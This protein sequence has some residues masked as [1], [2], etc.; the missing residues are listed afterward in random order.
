VVAEGDGWYA[1]LRPWQVDRAAAVE[2][3]ARRRREWDRMRDYMATR[4][5]L[6]AFLT[7]DLDDPEA[8]ACGHCANCLGRP[9][10]SRKAGGRLVRQAARHLTERRLQSPRPQTPNLL[11]TALKALF[12]R[13]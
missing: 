6:M 10:L 2:V 8:G 5:C 12:G 11:W 9:L 1:T 4:G 3:A 7:A 13:A